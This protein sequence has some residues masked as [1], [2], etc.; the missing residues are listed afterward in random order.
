MEIVELSL[1]AWADGF[2]SMPDL[3]GDELDVR[4]H[5]D[6]WRGYQSASVQTT[7]AEPGMRVWV[8]V[9]DDGHVVGFVAAIVRDNERQIGEIE[10]LAVDPAHQ[11]HGIGGALTE[12]ATTWLRDQGMRVAMIGTGGDPAHAPARRTY[13]KAGYT[14]LPL[15]RYFKAL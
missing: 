1:R 7:L 9:D 6:D 3:L 8:A 12:L 11:N 13:E 10:M 4:L 15:V 2:A 5:S 14:P